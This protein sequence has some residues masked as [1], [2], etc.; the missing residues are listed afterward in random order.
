M[1]RNDRP[2]RRDGDGRRLGRDDRA[3]S[4]AVTHALA[5]ATSAM[6]VV[7]LV[8]AMGSFIQDESERVTRE[9][10]ESLGARLADD[11]AAADRLTRRGASVNASMRV[12]ERL[13]DTQVSVAVERG[14]DCPVDTCLALR[15]PERDLTVYQ[16][17]ANRSAVS[18]SRAGG[19]VYLEADP[20]DA[21]PAVGSGPPAVAP[22]VGVGRPAGIGGGGVVVGNRDP[23]AGFVFDPGSPVAGTNV[24]FTNDT[25]DLDGQIAT[26]EWRFERPDGSNRT[27]PGPQATQQY[28]TPGVYTVTLEV[29]DDQ[30]ETDS[31]RREV[32]VSGLVLTDEVSELDVDGDG[33]ESGVNVTFENRWD[34]RVRVTTVAIDPDDGIEALDEDTVAH[35]VELDAGSDGTLDGY[36]E[37][38]GGVEV[39]DDGRIFDIDRDGE[40]CNGEPSYCDADVTVASNDT[41]SLSFTEL[42]DAVDDEVEVD[43]DPMDVAVRY[44][45][46]GRF[47]VTTVRLFDEGP[48]DIVRWDTPDDW[49]NATGSRNVTH[50]DGVVRL[51]AGAGAGGVPGA[52]S[53]LVVWL[54]L[55]ETGT[56]TEAIDYAPGGGGG[57][58][59]FDV[60]D[61]T[62]TTGVEGVSGVGTAYEFD[63]ESWLRDGNAGGTYLDGEDAVTLSMWVQA[64][65]TGTNRGLVDSD[66]DGSDGDDDEF[67]LRYDAS[68]YDTGGEDSFKS[69][70][71]LGDGITDDSYAYEYESD[72]QSTDWQHVTM[73]WAAGE[74]VELFVDGE[75][76]DIRSGSSSDT[77]ASAELRPDEFDFLALARS[78]KDDTD[79]L[80]EGRIDEVRIYDRALSDAAVQ[81][82]ADRGGLR[83]GNLTT[84]W[85]TTA[86]P[87]DLEE[88]ELGYDATLYDGAVEV[89]VQR[90]ADDGTVSSADPVLLS[91]DSGV[92]EVRG[93]AG[94]GDEFRLQVT[95]RGLEED[96]STDAFVL[97]D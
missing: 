25:E 79:A 16:P 11:V 28:D 27:V 2:S 67:G 97:R 59:Q 29:T 62:P 83:T 5:V 8:S 86:E 88:L 9:E 82:L 39:P 26:Y 96:P 52:S 4:S 23:V 44:R 64:D 69:S 34:E 43:D 12:P 32:P 56:P 50:P 3:V 10:L 68:G 33:I 15:A 80:W 66:D 18:L 6:L 40:D 55:N 89:V 36:V 20:A 37:Y 61:G 47:Y 58:Y 54:P 72:V 14:G 41:L 94:D 71:R 87:L 13:V 78:Q 90:R 19:A 91:G 70:I 17:L 22:T 63:G 74:P 57:G 60:V 42:R 49:D 95:Y 51:D 85:K 48:T 65:G 73:R 38:D 31:V 1:R 35:E 24:T 21:T 84:D 77:P 45:V 53:G 75:R 30:G 7:L 76:L 92:R 93:L 46:D 81:S